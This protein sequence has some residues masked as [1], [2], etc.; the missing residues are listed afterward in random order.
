M[1]QNYKKIIIGIIA[2]ILISIL[3]YVIINGKNNTATRFDGT[4]TIINLDDLSFVGTGVAVNNNVVTIRYGGS[5]EITGTTTIGRIV[6]DSLDSNDVNLLLNNASITSTDAPIEVSKAS[7]VNITLKDD[8]TNHIEYTKDYSDTEEIDGAIYSKSDLGFDGN[9]TIEVI[10]NYDGIVSKD[11]LVITSG[12]YNITTGDDGIRGKDSVVISDG[13]FTIDADGDGIKAT[14]DSDTSLGYIE[15]DNGTFN[16]TANNDGIQALTKLNILNGTFNITT[17]G[18]SLNASTKSDWGNWNNTTTSSNEESAKGIKGNN[19][20][21]DNGTFVLD[22]SDDS[23]HSNDTLE[24]KNGTYQISSGDDGMHADTSLNI[25]TGNIDILKSY[26]GIE[27]LT[28][29]IDGGNIRIVASDDGINAAGGNDS[30]SLN[31]AGANSFSTGNGKLT[32]NNGYL[33][34]DATGDGLDSNGSIYI[35]GGT[36]IVNGLT[37]DGNGALDYDSECIVTS[38]TLISSGSSGM[39]QSP[40]TSSTQYT[41]TIILDSNTTDL[42]HVVDSSGNNVLTF[43]PSKTTRSVVFTSP[44]LNNGETYTVYVGGTA[45]GTVTDGV[46]NNPT[47]SGGTLFKSGTISSLVTTIGTATTQNMP[48]RR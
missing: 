26:E 47:Y 32:I 29:T 24:I 5:Y 44:L 20:T 19:V 3:A 38:G 42:I 37:D 7:K 46:Y 25:N 40:S 12:T 31:R 22:T 15:I 28:I 11:S 34:V 33:Y 41:L 16:I 43:K 9:G 30:S 4:Q 23:I 17:G 8:T 48:G 36:T 10:S 18:G 27:S 35:N 1:K 21:I 45:T 39:L 2:L 13:I 6:I 14:N